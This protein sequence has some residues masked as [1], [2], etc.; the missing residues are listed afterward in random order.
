MYAVFAVLGGLVGHELWG[1]L[2]QLFTVTILSSTVLVHEFGHC[3]MG[4]GG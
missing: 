1:A 4:R 3:F 2:L